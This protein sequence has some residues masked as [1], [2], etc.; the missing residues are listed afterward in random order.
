MFDGWIT[1]DNVVYVIGLIVLTVGTIVS[2]KWRQ[3]VK[4]TTDIF[5]ELEKAL[6]DGKIDETEKKII[7]KEIIQAGYAIIKATWGVKIK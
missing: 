5:R 3:A 2:A 6:E 4:E 7:M 1:W